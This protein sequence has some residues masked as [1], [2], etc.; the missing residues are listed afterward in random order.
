M[1]ASLHQSGDPQKLPDGGKMSTESLRQLDA[2]DI[3]EKLENVLASMTAESYDA[4]MIDAYLDAIEEKSSVPPVKEPTESYEMWKKRIKDFSVQDESEYEP[5]RY[6]GRRP[7]YTGWRRYAAVAAATVCVVF[8]V[9]I[10]AQA[11]GTDVFGHL[12]Q[13]TDEVFFFILPT[14]RPSEYYAPFRDA[15]IE[16]D[17]PSELAPSWY[18]EGFRTN[19]PVYDEGN[20]LCDSV[21]MYF[22]NDEERRFSIYVDHYFAME[23]LAGGFYEKDPSDVELYTSNGRT[24]Y[25]MS[26]LNTVTAVWA[27]DD[28]AAMIE[29]FLSVEEMKQ[30]I[31]SMGE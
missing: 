4:E 10:G 26:N 24:F 9:M 11:M 16:H 13:W 29:G 21:Y 30:I 31:D 22:I 28:M 19:G 18:P 12:S 20:P 6:A 7:R 3:A 17:L 1:N 23:N 25:I 8:T 15:L 5:R 27:D 14:R 2:V